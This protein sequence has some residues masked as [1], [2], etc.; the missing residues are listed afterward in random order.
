MGMSEN[1]SL[2]RCA[3]V[4]FPKTSPLKTAQG[5]FSLHQIV[6]TLSRHKTRHQKKHGK[7]ELLCATPLDE[8][9]LMTSAKQFAFEKALESE[10]RWLKLSLDV[11][12][13]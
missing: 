12:H 7:Q 1:G 9:E 11:C 6:I 2:T 8:Y 13:V 10:Q 3:S 5:F 4:S